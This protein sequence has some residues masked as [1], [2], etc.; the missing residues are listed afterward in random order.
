MELSDSPI[1]VPDLEKAIARSPLTVSPDTLVLDAIAHMSQSRGQSCSLPSL[2]DSGEMAMNSEA[3][4][5][6][7]LVMQD[8]KLLGIFT[9]R[10]IVRLTAID[11][12]LETLKISEVMAQPVVTITEDNFK[13]IFAALFLFRRYR[14][15]H[16]PLTNNSGQLTG[17]VSPESIRQVLRPA[18]LLKMRRVA[19]VM[20]KTV[21]RASPE[22]SVLTI[23]QLMAA[24]RVSCVAIV[25]EDEDGYLRPVGIITERDIVQFRF[26]QLDLRTIP[27]QKV[28][29]TPLFLLSPEDS[30]WTAHQTMQQR[31]VRRLVVSWNWG[32]GLGIVT[33]SSLLRAFDPMEMYW[34]LES[35]QKTIQ[36]LKGENIEELQS[37]DPLRT[38]EMLSLKGRVLR[39]A[40]SD[41]LLNSIRGCLKTL[42]N[43]PELTPEL[44]QV[45]FQRAITDLAQLEQLL[46]TP[47]LKTD[48]N[49][50][51]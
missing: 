35:L 40:D 4:S 48:P 47:S 12:P 19:D 13:D 27:S 18:N 51:V 22:T 20:S 3:R 29:S 26:L 23:A 11:E 42:A 5:S 38:T 8:A 43:T 6:C 34:T 28:M 37:G 33:Q 2:E 14:I 36:Q 41:S 17:V 32:R 45:E 25:E 46:Q 7:V 49:R 30:L 24:Q 10:D 16:L 31:R 15:R 39:S 9:E 50:A 44:R 1:S 21:I